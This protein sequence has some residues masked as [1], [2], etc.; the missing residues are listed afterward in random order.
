MEK[1][2]NEREW[3]EKRPG[4]RNGEERKGRKPFHTAR[5]E[6]EMDREINENQL[7]GRNAILEVLRSGRD[8]EKIM[9]AKGNVEGTIKRIIAMAVEKG[10]VTETILY[11]T[12]F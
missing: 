11:Q 4:G 12:C 2:R 7:E 8:I 6:R 1:R 5:E 9:V 3:K 10:V